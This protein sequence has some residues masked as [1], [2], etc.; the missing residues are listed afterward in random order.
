MSVSFAHARVNQELA[1][2]GII[3]GGPFW[4]ATWPSGAPSAGLLLHLIPSVIVIA[5]IPFG[6]A[7][8]FIVN[9]E[10]YARALVF[11][12][13]VVGLFIL[14]WR[15]PH[16]RR[17]FRVWTPVAVFFAIGQVVVLIAPFLKPSKTKPNAIPYWVYPII[18]IC[19]F[20]LGGIYWLMWR[21]VFPRIWSYEIE[22]K[23]ISRGDGTVVM[24][25]SRKK[26]A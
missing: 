24:S 19:V 5:A 9:V 22:E 4:A 17:L 18:G 3:P 15:S 14:R 7:F 1:K 2:E 13:V 6:E 10:Q 11:F 26:R 12:F 25:F 8:N 21:K 16:G 20:I 23:K